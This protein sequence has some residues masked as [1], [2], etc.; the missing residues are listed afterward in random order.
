MITRQPIRTKSVT[1]VRVI[2]C[3]ILDARHSN[4]LFSRCV[5]R[6]RDVGEEASVSL[7]NVLRLYDPLQF[8]SYLFD[9]TRNTGKRAATAICESVQLTL[10]HLKLVSPVLLCTS[11]IHNRIFTFNIPN[12]TTKINVSL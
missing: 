10:C 5:T 3:V 11:D 1:P 7:R 2:A 6:C 12:C 8:Y 9:G 4:E